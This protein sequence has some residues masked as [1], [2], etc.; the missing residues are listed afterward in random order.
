MVGYLGF[1][2]TF[3]YALQLFWSTKIIKAVLD[4]GDETKLIEPK[5]KDN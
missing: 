2:L 1:I 4:G 3:L 5:L